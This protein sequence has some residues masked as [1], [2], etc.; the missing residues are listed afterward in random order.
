MGKLVRDHIPAIMTADGGNPH[1]T[2]LDEPSY[3]AALLAKLVEEASEAQVATSDE[4]IGELAD[5]WEVL[6]A[7]ITAHGLTLQ[8]VMDE[9]DRKRQERGSF[10]NRVWLDD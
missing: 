6:H 3:R 1:I 7:T 10:T 5:L 9:A 2:V 8:A 4:L